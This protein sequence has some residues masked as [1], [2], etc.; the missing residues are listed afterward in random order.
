MQAPVLLTEA[1]R[2]GALRQYSI[3]HTAPEQQFD[4]LTRLVVQIC[5]TPI[6]TT[7]FIDQRCQWFKFCVDP[8]ACES[9]R[10]IS[11]CA[12]TLSVL[13]EILGKDS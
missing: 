6:S 9:P 10:D 4:D 3:L 2:R 5:G 7:T 12:H 13:A 1:A 8:A 11:I